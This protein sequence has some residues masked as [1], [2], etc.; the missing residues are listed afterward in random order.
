MA[1]QQ[2]TTE[3]AEKLKGSRDTAQ[4]ILNKMNVKMGGINYTIIPENIL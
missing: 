4:N 3:V 1:T 2:V